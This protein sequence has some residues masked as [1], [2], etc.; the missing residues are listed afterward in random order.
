MTA[1]DQPPYPGLR[2]FERDESDL[3]FGRD[4]CINDMLARFAATRF[5]AVLGSSGTGKSSLVKTGFFSALEMGRLSGAGSRWRIVELRPVDDPLG[6][7]ARAL[8]KTETSSDGKSPDQA[9][10][11]RLRMQ[12]RREGPRELL[13]WCDEG[14]LAAGT[15]LLLLVDQFEELFRYGNDEQREEAQA[16]VSLL[17]ESRWPRGVK[18]PQDAGVPIYVTIT[19]RSEFLG[20]CALIRGLAEAINEGT[21]LTPRMTRQQCQD[22]IVGPARVCG[23]EIEDRLVAK[24]LND[25]AAFAPWEHEVETKDQLSRLARRADQLPLMQHALNRMWQRAR[26]KHRDG[27]EITLKLA[28]YR[29]LEQELDD[30]AEQVLGRLDASVRPTAECVFR[31]VTFGTTVA[32]AVR[33]PTEYGDLVKICG[34]ESRDAVANVIAAFGPGGCQFLTSNIRQT[35]E[36]LPDDAWIDIAHESLIRQWKTLSA[37]LEKEG[38]ASREWRQLKDDADRGGFLYGR[39]LKD[40]V[41][42]RDEV[43]PNDEWAKRY[44]GGFDRVTWLVKKSEWL[45]LGLVVT[46]ALFVLAAM[47]ISTFIYQQ[48]VEKAQKTLVATQNFELTVLSAQRL[49]DQVSTSFE[50]GDIGVTGAKDMLKVA[51][52]IV[53]Q[54]RDPEKTTQTVA[55]FMNLLNTVSDIQADL[56]NYTE[57]YRTAST[58]RDFAQSLRAADADNPEVLQLLYAST[59]RMGDAISSRGADRALQE[60]ALKEYME[61]EQL[62]SQLARSA[63][64]DLARQ[65]DRM[66]IHQKIGDVRQALGDL[67]AAI[68][69]YRTALALIQNVAAKEPENRRWRREV[70]TTLRRIG[71]ALSSKGDL[72]GALGQL[73]AALEIMT[74]LAQADPNDGVVQSNVAGNHHDIAVV[75]VQRADLDAALAEYTLAIGIQEGLLDKDPANATWQ[76]S[77]ASFYTEMG[78]VLRRR[79]DLSG[80]LERNRMAYTLRQRLAAKDPANPNRQNN[81]A[82]AA[83]SIADLLGEQKQNLNEAVKLYRDAIVILDELRPRYDRNVFDCYIKIGNILILQDNREGA[84][85][86]YKRAN[87]IARDSAAS[88]ASSV[89]WQRNLTTS[90]IKIGDLLAAQERTREAL[91]HY[92]QALEIVTALAAKDAKSVEWPPLIEE[93]K[94]KI[95]TLQSKL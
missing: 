22:A 79:G 71:Q 10:I 52:Q 68:A 28:D 50:H 7:L 14:H 37:W 38:R 2:P 93:L 47:A 76:Y 44:G 67:D 92:Q 73:R 39:R 9:E 57:A 11:A 69:E 27:E 49:L 40:A 83:I 8:L 24:L 12:F 15:N 5:L 90:H 3:F 74:D 46:G 63:P 94:A 58:A 4:D 25:M 87:A 86:E 51:G 54:V 30:H 95:R 53:D 48:H 72:D 85:T 45:K 21:F 59:W 66:F 80:A 75:H 60:Q 20:A 64:G 31:A 55:L 62:V 33:R 78:T 77:L 18:S 91:E 17:L 16:F 6:N 32:D 34:A 81:L 13:K 89:I 36:R 82:T 43:K 61:A 35:G 84:L 56:G 1:P 42:L 70:A 65:R 41:A 88:N 29:G 19:M 23:I 26:Q